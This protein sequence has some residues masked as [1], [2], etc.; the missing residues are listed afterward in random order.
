MTGRF[1]SFVN[2]TKMLILVR[3]EGKEW[4]DACE[5]VW[6]DVTGICWLRDGSCR[7]S[8]CGADMWVK[9]FTRALGWHAVLKNAEIWA[10]V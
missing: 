9:V 1:T 6:S 2:I 3:K 8:V 10:V 7:G 5:V 4:E